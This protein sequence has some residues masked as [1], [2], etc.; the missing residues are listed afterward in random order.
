MVS[1]VS[2]IDRRM[3]LIDLLMPTST[4]NPD[5]SREVPVISL[6]SGRIVGIHAGLDD[7]I[8]EKVY[9]PNGLPRW[10]PNK[11]L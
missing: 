7:K 6:A 2:Q 1:F 11:E 4:V 5:I 10:R 9:L 3:T 8:Q